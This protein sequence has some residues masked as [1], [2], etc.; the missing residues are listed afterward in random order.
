MLNRTITCVN[1]S[2]QTVTEGTGNCTTATKPV[3]SQPCGPEGN[4][5]G[6]WVNG[7]ASTTGITEY[8]WGTCSGGTEISYVFCVN[9][10]G[11][12][13]P[14]GTGNC[15]ASTKPGGTAGFISRPCQNISTADVY[16]NQ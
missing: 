1:S 3:S 2:G 14:D 11:Q 16:G 12:R 9:S 4:S 7:L 6:R 15:T 5:V 10:S 13:V 8:A